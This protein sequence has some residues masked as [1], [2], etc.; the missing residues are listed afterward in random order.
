M[1]RPI[2]NAWWA[3]ESATTDLEWYLSRMLSFEEVR[4]L[5]AGPESLVERAQ[6]E[7]RTRRLMSEAS[8][9]SVEVTVLRL[10]FGFDEHSP[11]T[12][13]EVGAEIGLCAERVRRIQNLALSKLKLKIVQ[14]STTIERLM[15]VLG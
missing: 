3:G 7:S 13:A 4:L 1:S 6:I 12:L 9:S 15:G 11:H 10:R 8:L 14:S 5:V 2:V